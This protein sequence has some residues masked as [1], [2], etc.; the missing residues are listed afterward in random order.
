MVEGSFLGLL[1]V[2][3]IVESAEMR[4]SPAAGFSNQTQEGR[5]IVDCKFCSFFI[6]FFRGGGCSVG[7]KSLVSSCCGHLFSMAF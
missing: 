2:A 4:L 3:S 7:L 1:L 6:L 5:L